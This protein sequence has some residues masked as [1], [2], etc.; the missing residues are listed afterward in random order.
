MPAQSIFLTVGQFGPALLEIDTKV[1]LTPFTGGGG[2][3]VSI[4]IQ[5]PDLTTVNLVGVVVAVGKPDPVTNPNGGL[6]TV[7]VPGGTFSVAGLYKVQAKLANAASLVI[8]EVAVLT[9]SA[10]FAR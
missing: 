9:I 4:D 6:F 8:G 5:K 1:D 10:P 3:S 7:D 2:A